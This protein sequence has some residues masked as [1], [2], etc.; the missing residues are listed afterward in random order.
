MSDLNDALEKIDVEWLLTREG[1]SYKESYGRSGRQLNARTCPFCHTSEY[2]I[3]INAE[4]GIGN[5]FSGSCPQKTFNKW[6]LCKG[7]F[8]LE[9]RNLVNLIQELAR[10]QG[11]RPMVKANNLGLQDINTLDIPPEAVPA[12]QMD[13]MPEYLVRRGITKDLAEHFS[14][15]W[16]EKGVWRF[17]DPRGFQ[18][19]QDYSNRILLPI[20]DLNGEMVSFQGRDTTGEA[21]QR[22]LFPPGFASAG[23]YLYNAVNVAEGTETVVVSE[24]VFDVIQVKRSLV[25]NPKTE[26][27]A[28]IGT[29]G[30]H[31][32]S[33]NPS[34]NDQ[35]G[36]LRQLKRE[37]GVKRV[38]FLWDGERKAAAE[39]I[40]VGLECIKVGLQV[41]IGL[42]PD[43]KDPGNSNPLQIQEAVINALPLR[44][45]LDAVRIAKIVKDT[46][47]TL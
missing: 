10:E 7:I 32:S 4:S 15:Y 42:V 30:M 43:G 24:G 13:V 17:M 46:Y 11:W 12:W 40:R 23:A 8:E 29:F 1:I 37:R 38:I 18:G 33:G 34:G 22:Y 19:K 39:A 16:S 26:H 9:G 25:M 47:T 35:L 20:F 41:C 27:M 36:R 6:S 44:T 31:L 21:E 45:K 14:L 28:P 2:K 5:C 3:Y